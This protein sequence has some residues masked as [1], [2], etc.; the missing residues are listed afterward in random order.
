MHSR[1]RV[2]MCC[3][4]IWVKIIYLL[5]LVLCLL[6]YLGPPSSVCPTAPSPL[7]PC[8]LLPLHC[9]SLHVSASVCGPPLQDAWRSCSS[10]CAEFSTSTTA[11]FSSTGS[12]PRPSSSRRSVRINWVLM[13]NRERAS[14]PP[15]DI[16]VVSDVSLTSRPCCRV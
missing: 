11:P 13:I 3:V 16:R 8:L 14:D 10:A 5:Y 7:R 12:S 4:Q 2:C 15:G 1:S 9:P 6:E